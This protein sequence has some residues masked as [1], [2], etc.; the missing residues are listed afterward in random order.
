MQKTPW[1]P[2]QAV[3]F[4]ERTLRQQGRLLVGIDGRC[5]SGKT[6]LAASL[7][8]QLGAQ[9]IHMDDF[10]LPL[11]QRA[12]DWESI[13][14]GNMDLHRF[15]REVLHPLGRGEGGQY[16]PYRCALGQYD[17]PQRFE[18]APLVVVEGSYS[19][20]P[21][22]REAYGLRLFV[23]CGKAVQAQRLQAREGAHYEAY[24]QRW[25]PLEE[26]Y[27]AACGLPDEAGVPVYTVCTD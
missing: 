10:Y 18:A 5:G 1:Q 12:A 7:Q 6:T 24:V 17:A 19:L 11:A 8:A 27:F 4:I 25:I 26:R 21:L 2:Q 13:P 14:A 16:R 3:Q 20:H 23:S 9:V 15:V 22:L